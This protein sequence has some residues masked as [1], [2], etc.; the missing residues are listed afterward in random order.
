MIDFER[1]QLDQVKDIFEKEKSKLQ[2]LAIQVKERGNEL[3]SFS[4]YVLKQKEETEMIRDNI[5]ILKDSLDKQSKHLEQR[6]KLMNQTESNLA[7]EYSRLNTEW[8][9][10]NIAKQSILCSMCNMSINRGKFDTFELSFII[11]CKSQVRK[12]T[13]LV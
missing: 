13:Q 12:K 6:V 2:Q 10:L 3:E 7:Q 9:E 8:N 11:L 5:I 1:Q 4:E